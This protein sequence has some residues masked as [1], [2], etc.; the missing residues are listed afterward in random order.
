[1]SSTNA[2]PKALNYLAVNCDLEIYESTIDLITASCKM[3]DV[4]VKQRN[5]RV[6]R[7]QREIGPQYC[8]DRYRPPMLGITTFRHHSIRQH[9]KYCYWSGHI[10]PFTDQA[11]AHGVNGV[12]NRAVRRSA[13]VVR[14]T[15]NSIPAATTNDVRSTLEFR[16]LRP[17]PLAIP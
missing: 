14:S 3:S 4:D 15:A 16:C 10:R 7:R 1:M 8:M 12:I 17:E 13:M 2:I 9:S 11:E 6:N 5:S